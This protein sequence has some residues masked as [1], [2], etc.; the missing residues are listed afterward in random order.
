MDHQRCK[1]CRRSTASVIFCAHILIGC[2]YTCPAMTRN[3]G[4]VLLRLTWTLA[5]GPGAK[6]RCR[7]HTRFLDRLKLDHILS[8]KNSR[9]V[10]YIAD[11]A[12]YYETGRHRAEVVM[13]GK[14]KSTSNCSG[15][16]PTS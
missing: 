3:H 11:V 15:S 4:K 2:D 14:M 8:D 1:V 5:K 9:K 12:I 10:Y 7:E 13:K 6:Y 16:D